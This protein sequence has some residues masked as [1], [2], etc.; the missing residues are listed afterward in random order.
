M[1]QP[2]RPSCLVAFRIA[3]VHGL[4]QQVRAVLVRLVIAGPA[5]VTIARC[6]VE[7]R[8]TI[9]IVVTVPFDA[10]SLLAHALQVP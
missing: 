10:C 4:A 6:R 2:V 7:V 3:I 5:L 8:V 1:I 9:V